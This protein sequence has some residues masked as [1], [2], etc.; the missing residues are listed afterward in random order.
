MNRS[1]HPPMFR[2]QLF[3]RLD[4]LR[5]TQHDRNLAATGYGRGLAL[6]AG[7]WLHGLL[8]GDEVGNPIH[9]LRLDAHCVAD[10]EL[11]H[12]DAISAQLGN[13]KAAIFF[14]SL[15]HFAELNLVADFHFPAPDLTVE[16]S[17]HVTSDKSTTVRRLA[18]AGMGRA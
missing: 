7:L 3:Q 9:G 1:S 14:P 10:R 11:G 6:R 13:Y 8:G 2:G 18:A 15:Q 5:V 17:S 16:P 12:K 4:D